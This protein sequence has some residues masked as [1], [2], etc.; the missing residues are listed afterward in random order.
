MERYADENVSDDSTKHR[1]IFSGF[2]LNRNELIRLV[3]DPKD[4]LTLDLSE[5]LPGNPLWITASR[6]MLQIAI[7]RDLFSRTTGQK[8][9][10]PADF[11]KNVEFALVERSIAAIGLARRSGCI[12]WGNKK[13]ETALRKGN[14]VLRIEAIDGSIN[15][16]KKLDK[17]ANVP[18]VRSLSSAELARAFRRTH[19]VHAAISASNCAS[20]SRLTARLIKDFNRLGR[21]RALT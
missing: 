20:N 10:I 16:Q 4:L 15:G 19:I 9:I 21:F 1:C 13:V 14:V 8:V 3:L 6:D 11:V 12:L 17:I 5:K 2:E 7:K 18:V